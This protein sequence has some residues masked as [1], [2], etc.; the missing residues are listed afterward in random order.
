MILAVIVDSDD[1]CAFG[2]FAMFAAVY[3]FFASIYGSAEKKR[4]KEYSASKYTL[5]YKITEFKGQIDTT[6]VLIPK[7]NN[8]D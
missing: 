8:H 4:P 6:Y 7:E 1:L 3:I 5:S 2:G